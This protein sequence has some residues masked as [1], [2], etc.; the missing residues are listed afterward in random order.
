MV[1]DMNF[2]G[3]A[4]R[5]IRLTAAIG[6]IAAAV[7]LYWGWQYSAGAAAGALFQVGFLSFL[8]MKYIKWAAAG[9]AP[10]EIGKRLVGFTGA[11]L[12]FEI[13]ACVIAAVLIKLA[14]LG[15]LA[16]LL[17]LMVATVLDKIIHVIKE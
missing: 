15:F 8:R 14:V 6:I 3:Y 5:L 2:P 1:H 4:R 7:S 11:R 13:G 9:C 17:S 12:F 16:G 10:D